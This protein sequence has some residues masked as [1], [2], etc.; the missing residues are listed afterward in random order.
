MASSVLL[1]SKGTCQQPFVASD[2]V[3]YLELDGT[4]DVAA[5]GLF[6]G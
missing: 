3:K 4:F 6:L 1:S 2:V 5:P